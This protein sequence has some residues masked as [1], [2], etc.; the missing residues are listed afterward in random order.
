MRRP[1]RGRGE[2][3]RGEQRDVKRVRESGEE[4]GCG[5]EDLAGE[6]WVGEFLVR[7]EDGGEHAV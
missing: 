2:Q 3:L 1:Y 4:G 6:C 5:A 7:P